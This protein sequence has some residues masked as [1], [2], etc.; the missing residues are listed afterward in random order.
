MKKKATLIFPIKGYKIKLGIKQRGVGAGLYNGWGGKVEPGQTIRENLA[1]EFKTETGGAV[2]SPDKIRPV[3]LIHFFFFGNDTDIPDFDV[4]VYIAEEIIGTIH[5]T[6]EMKNEKDFAFD[7]VPYD[8]MMPADR[9]FVAK[10]L[11]G[12]TFF[13]RVYFNEDK[14]GLRKSSY[15]EPRDPSL[16]EI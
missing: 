11:N 15:Y 5:D 12:E 16:L 10:I 6:D 9:E 8:H 3:A 14:T 4:T 7:G 1:E 2:C 13:G